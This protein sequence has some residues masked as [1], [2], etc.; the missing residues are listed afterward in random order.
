MTDHIREFA[1][2]VDCP[3]IQALRGE[4]KHGDFMYDPA[5]EAIIILCSYCDTTENANWIEYDGAIWLPPV[6][7]IS[8]PERSMVGAIGYNIVK[9]VPLTFGD[10]RT[11]TSWRV[12]VWRET[13]HVM[14]WFEGPII[15]IAMAKALKW[16]LTEGK[17]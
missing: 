10:D 2:I 16:W 13:V 12:G 4:W 15:E 9:M 17:K 3:E 6:S 8:H 5:E 14:R 11:A 7:S 1:S